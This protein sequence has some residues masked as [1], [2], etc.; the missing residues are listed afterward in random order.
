VSAFVCTH[1]FLAKV[2]KDKV[3]IWI[4]LDFIVLFIVYFFQIVCMC[5]SQRIYIF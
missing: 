3:N 1:W 4:S 2:A 5:R